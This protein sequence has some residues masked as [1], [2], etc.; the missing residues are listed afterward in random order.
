MLNLNPT[1]KHFV[2]TIAIT[3]SCVL[4]ATAPAYAQSGGR[5]PLVEPIAPPIRGTELLDLEPRKPA[6]RQTV[7]EDTARIRRINRLITRLKKLSNEREK[8]SSQPQP[9]PVPVDSTAPAVTTTPPQATIQQTPPP[10]PPTPTQSTPLPEPVAPAETPPMMIVKEPATATETAP[11]SITSTVDKLALAN[12]LF[13]QGKSSTAK[14]IYEKLA[15][16]PQDPSDA[17]WIRYQLACCYRI[18]GQIKEAIKLY[19]NVGG[20]K[21]DSYWASRAQWWLDFIGRSQQLDEK[22]NSL[23]KQLEKLK[24]AIDDSNAK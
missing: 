23:E 21:V 17:V 24:K 18:D 8:V 16:T 19:R 3:V 12:N 13:A 14:A 4:T 15:S 20:N 5:L 7:V 11:V 9:L 22:R 2:V 10:K 1:I 6:P